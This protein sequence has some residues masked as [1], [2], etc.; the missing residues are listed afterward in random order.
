M[1]IRMEVWGEYALFTRPEMKAERVSYDVITPSAAR[2]LLE[3]VFWHPGLKWN[4]CS[5]RVC[6]P[7]EFAN[8]RRNEV[9]SV[10]SLKTARTVMERGTGELWLVTSEDIQQRAATLLKNV[11]YVIEAEF[12]MTDKASPTDNPGKFQE[13]TKRR[14]RKGQFYSQPYLGC[15]EFPAHFRLCETLPPIPDCLKGERD[16]GFMLYDMDYSDPENITPMFFRAI[17]VDGVIQV[18][19]P[20]SVEVRR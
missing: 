17:M 18:P 1:S 16:L 14:L 13:I 7:I 20:D 4:I 5:I 11:H 12:E 8:I 2:G 19:R 15:R 3:S 10:C 9:K 6:A